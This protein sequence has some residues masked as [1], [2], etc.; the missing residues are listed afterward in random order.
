MTDPAQDV[1][2]T[3]PRIAELELGVF[4]PH[5]EADVLAM[6]I[7]QMQGKRL[8]QL[9]QALHVKRMVDRYGY[10]RERMAKLYSRSLLGR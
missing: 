10:T 9:E 2:T 7:N 3:N 1:S 8:S 6:R 4:S 5:N